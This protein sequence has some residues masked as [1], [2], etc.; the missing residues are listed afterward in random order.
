MKNKIFSAWGY[1]I[2]CSSIIVL[3]ALGGF[4]ALPFIHGVNYKRTL[5]F[6]VG[7][8]VGTLAGSSLL[9]LIPEVHIL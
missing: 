5:I 8:A 6:M 4:L 2:L 9:F 1:G 3:A 7:L